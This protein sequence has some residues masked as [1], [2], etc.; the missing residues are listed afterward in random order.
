MSAQPGY[1]DLDPEASTLSTDEATTPS[2]FSTGSEPFLPPLDDDDFPEAHDLGSRYNETESGELV[3]INAGNPQAGISS[4][5]EF[6]NERLGGLLEQVRASQD[7]VSEMLQQLVSG[8]QPDEELMRAISEFVELSKFALVAYE[9]C[10]NK[11]D[12]IFNRDLTSQNAELDEIRN[13]LL[14]VIKQ[15]TDGRNELHQKLVGLIA[16]K[17]EDDE[18]ARVL[19]TSVFGSLGVSDDSDFDF[20]WATGRRVFATLPDE[21]IEFLKRFNKILDDIV[22]EAKPT[23]FF[24]TS[25][26]DFDAGKFANSD[27]NLYSGNS[28]RRVVGDSFSKLKNSLIQRWS[29]LNKGVKT[30][31]KYIGA[32]GIAVGVLVVGVRSCGPD[33]ESAVVDVNS[34]AIAET[35]TV[36][37]VLQNAN[38]DVLINPNTGKPFTDQELD[39]LSWVDQKINVEGYTETQIA[40]M[41]VNLAA[42]QPVEIGQAAV[43]ERTENTPIVSRRVGG[44]ASRRAQVS[45]RSQAA[46][47]NAA[48]NNVPDATFD[49]PST[50]SQQTTTTTQAP[51]SSTTTTT[52]STTTVAPT[53]TTT[54]SVPN[55][56]STTTSIVSS[57]PGLSPIAI[58]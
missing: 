45:A 54:S 40:E 19:A 7:L 4:L 13:D 51:A 35:P 34:D 22:K 14:R 27:E 36:D 42:T 11:V 53:T 28:V 20:E 39:F 24:R 23:S 43:A 58:G 33:N 38:E 49:V 12:R 30:A 31:A 46:Q 57:P 17:I 1:F 50:T 16:S 32:V 2:P 48:R 8:Q 25:Q 52:T 3:A 10:A 15:K 9:S 26:K 44:D 18:Q 55:A 6:V 29:G 21:H 41:F 37:P 5:G 56:P 47:R